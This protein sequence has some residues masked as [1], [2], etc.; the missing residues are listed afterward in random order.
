MPTTAPETDHH[1]FCERCDRDTP[2]SVA[3]ELRTESDR[4]ENTEFSREPYRVSTC[5]SCDGTT[6]LR[7]NDA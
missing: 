5:M 7:M 2:H 6:A 3:I 4:S 1:E